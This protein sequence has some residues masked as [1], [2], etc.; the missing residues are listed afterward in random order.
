MG[1][2][3]WA[4]DRFE[5]DFENDKRNGV[6]L[7]T[8]ENGDSYLG[9]YMDNIKEGVGRKIEINRFE[10]SGEFKDGKLDGWGILKLDENGDVY[11]G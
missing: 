8:Y 4:G 11:E 10:Y 9:R 3:E 5:G 7:Y 6:G 1:D 2:S